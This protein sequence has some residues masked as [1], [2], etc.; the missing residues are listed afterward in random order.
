MTEGTSNWNPY[1]TTS[2]VATNTIQKMEV[3]KG[4]LIRSVNTENPLTQTIKFEGVLNSPGDQAITVTRTGTNG[5]NCIGNPYT[6]AIKI[7][8]GTETIETDNFINVNNGNFDLDFY[9]AYFWNDAVGQKKYDIINKSSGVTYAQ[10]GQGFFI[11]KKD[12]VTVTAMS[13]TPAMQFH[14]GAIALKS[15]TVSHPTIQLV[16]TSGDLKTSTDI[17]FI[18]GT[19]KGLDV[20]YD[21][22]ILKADPSFALYTKLV[23]P[24]DAEFQL[25]CLP[26]NQYNNLVIPIGIDSKAAGE[27]VLSVNTVQ[28]DPN[29]RVIL[30]DKLTS[31]FTDLSKNSYKAAVVANTAGTGRFYLHTGDIVSGLEDQSISEG[32]LTA[33]A[34]GNKEIRVLGEVGDGAVATLFNGLGQVVLTKKLGAGSQ[35]I[36]GLTTLSS[37]VYL[38]NINDKGAPQTIKIM[39]RK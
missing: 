30:E 2:F 9:G 1:F 25:Q 8:D 6:S 10:V 3:G 20:G 34:K 14:Q 4:Y 21:A 23:E 36:I 32:K 12:D 37:G 13:V 28:L 17:K 15:G 7:Y 16:A 19:S 5:W 11:R 31:T 22:G 38:L 35:N 39:V 18:D 29:C 24:Y 26:T 33:Y 27:I